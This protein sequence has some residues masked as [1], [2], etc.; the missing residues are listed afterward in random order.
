M[1]QSR[2]RNPENEGLNPKSRIAASN[3]RSRMQPNQEPTMNRYQASLPRA[4]L[5]IA[6]VAM[7]AVTLGLT[8]LPAIIGNDG[9]VVVP[10]VE[11]AQGNVPPVEVAAAHA[12]PIVGTPIVVY[13]YRDHD[14]GLKKVHMPHVA[15]PQKQRI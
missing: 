11:I 7:T 15:P 4:V 1:Q 8:I 10:A 12:T 9:R 3:D 14:T 6:A 5:S 13:G 2:R